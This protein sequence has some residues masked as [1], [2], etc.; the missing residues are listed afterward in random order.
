MSDRPKLVD[1][2]IAHQRRD[3]E[4]CI[5]GWAELGKSH[6]RHQEAMVRAAVG[7]T[8]GQQVVL[9][10]DGT[11]TVAERE[12]VAEGHVTAVFDSD[13]TAEVWHDPDDGPCEW[14]WRIPGAES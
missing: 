3:S 11:L 2:L 14:V 1:V 12:C 13:G 7:A 8:E 10:G 6:S 5:C 9:L 4:S